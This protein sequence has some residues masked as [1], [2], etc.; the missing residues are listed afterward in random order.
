MRNLILFVVAVVSLSSCS[1]LNKSRMLKTPRNY[2]FKTFTDSVKSEPYT[3]AIDDEIFI[4]LYSNDGYNFISLSGEQRNADQNVGNGQNRNRN[5]LYKVRTDSTIKVPVIGS[6]KVV[7]LTLQ[8]LELRFENLLKNHFNDP[9]VIASISN[10]RVF[11]FKGGSTASVIT[12]DNE[13]TTLF[14]V[15]AKSGGLDNE[16]NASRVKIIRG[17][18]SNPEIFMIDLSTIDGMKKSNLNMKAGDIIYVDPYFNYANRLTNDL[19]SIL[20]LI[21]SLLVIYTLTQG[22]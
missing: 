13:N 5:D 10:K 1:T 17:Q 14:E 22:N 20:G 12:L 7:G 6:V 9:F 19:G 8:Q 3:I 15:I 18:L 16:S 4:L 21:S 11:L 2:E